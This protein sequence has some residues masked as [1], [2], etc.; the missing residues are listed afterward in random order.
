MIDSRQHMVVRL[1]NSRYRGGRR[2][3]ESVDTLVMH[4]TAGM[5][6][7]SSIRWLNRE[8]AD[9]KASYHYVIERDGIILRHTPP[10]L[11]AFHAGD[12]AWPNPT[13][14]PP[15]NGSTINGRSIGIAWANKNDGEQL[16]EEQVKSGLWLCL[17]WMQRLGISPS[18]VCMHYECSPSRKTDP[19]PAMTGKEWRQQLVDAL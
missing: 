18:R 5:S 11:V 12:S 3:L 17:F 15:G 13:H 16:T 2:D 9:G 1:D 4:A 8:D 10:E 19:K 6:G 14:Y 7:M